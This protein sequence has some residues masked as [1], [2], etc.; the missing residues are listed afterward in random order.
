MADFGEQTTADE[1]AR[2]YS[3]SITG[4]TIVLTGGTWGGIG[5][6]TIRVLSIHGASVIFTARK[7]PI[8]ND[9]ISNVKKEAPDAN[10]KGILMDLASFDSVKAAAEEVSQ[11]T[12][13]IDILINNAG[14]MSTEYKTSSDGFEYDFATNHLGHFLFTGLLTPLLLKSN[15]PRV[16]NVSSIATNFAPVLFDDINFTEKK[17]TFTPFVAYSQTKTANVLFAKELN[18][19]YEKLKTFSVHPGLVR[20]N[21]VKGLS[22][23]EDLSPYDY[24]GNPILPE[25]M[26]S[27]YTKTVA[28]GAA[29]T[30]VAVVNDYFPSGSF[31]SDCQDGEE[32]LAD[33]AKSTENA[34]KLWK[35]SES[36]IG[37]KFDD[38]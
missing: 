17:E 3:N 18:E 28:E 1:V 12:S 23:F 27:V 16:I 35:V 37:Q 15:S 11:V 9:T 19:R 26:S 32:L 24:W 8:V 10:I 30:M 21:A 20:T 7:E 25:D 38:T 5:A 22:D 6:E 29:T 33:Y 4:K 36:F 34:Q 2:R 13:K 31:L 14:V